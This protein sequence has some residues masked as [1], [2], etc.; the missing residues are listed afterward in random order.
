MTNALRRIIDN[1]T[2]KL[3]N[4]LNIWNINT[5]KIL[6]KFNLDNSKKRHLI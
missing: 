6:M 5:K 2:K 3:S 4:S 1:T